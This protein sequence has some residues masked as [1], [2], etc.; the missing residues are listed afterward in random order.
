MEGLYVLKRRMR[1]VTLSVFYHHLKKTDF[2]EIT[3]NTR[4]RIPNW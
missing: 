1:P 2:H 3:I 4:R